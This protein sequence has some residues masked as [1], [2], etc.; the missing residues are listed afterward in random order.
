MYASLPW[1]CA[2]ALPGIVSVHAVHVYMPGPAKFSRLLQSWALHSEGPP[3]QQRH[4]PACL[5][6]CLMIPACRVYAGWLCFSQCMRLPNSSS[7]SSSSSSCGMPSVCRLACFSQC[8][9]LPCLHAAAA[10]ACRVHAVPKHAGWPGLSQCMRLPCLHAAAAAAC[11]VHA[12]PK[13]AGW[14]GLS[15]CMR[16]PCLHAV[17]SEDIACDSTV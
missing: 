6:C 11:R 3:V 9:R 2:V 10:A 8:M 14:P 16:L 1:L 12:V 15:Q 5:C 4:M 13:H 7:S 17:H